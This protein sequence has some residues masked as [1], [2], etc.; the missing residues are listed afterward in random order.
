[1][2]TGTT[3]VYSLTEAKAKLA[4]EVRA[5]N[6]SNRLFFNHSSA[7][8]VELQVEETDLLVW[9]NNQNN[10]TKIFWEDRN[11]QCTVAAIGTADVAIAK[12]GG[13]Y[14][15]FMGRLQK[16]LSGR[17]P[18]LRY[19]GGFCFSPHYPPQGEWANWNLARFVLPL[20]EIRR[21]P[22]GTTLAC[23]ILLSRD[24]KNTIQDACTQLVNLEGTE[25]GF[26]NILSAPYRRTDFPDVSTWKASAAHIINGVNEGKYEKLVLARAVKLDFK[27]HV[28]PF[29]LM[30]ELRETVSKC[31]SFI[32]QFQD[33]ECFLGTSPERLYHRKGE[34]IATEA[35]AGTRPR[36]EKEV[37][38]TSL[39]NHKTL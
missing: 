16:R 34:A 3:K 37:E 22:S 12:A 10:A 28:N 33:K 38:D 23:N 17:F 6:V 4:E 36:A 21:T 13:D 25:N 5:L 14:G 11:G 31:F 7:Y 29:V 26:A 30:S 19:Y 15:D 39:Q 20:I 2:T 27:E 24:I 8:R 18:D 1:M 32:F 9:L 35:L